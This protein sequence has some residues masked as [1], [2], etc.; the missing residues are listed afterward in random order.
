MQK[1]KQ[2]PFVFILLSIVILLS[3]FQGN[4]TVYI[5]VSGTATKY[6]YNKDCRGLSACT[7]DIKA[8]KL[9]EAKTVG[10]TLC[11]WED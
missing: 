1:S 2:I 11:G 5:C 4:S 3:S 7:H 6:H 10:R 8:I 9:S